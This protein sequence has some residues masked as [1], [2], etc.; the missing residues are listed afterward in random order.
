VP[1]LW[2][3]PRFGKRRASIQERREAIGG[4]VQQRLTVELGLSLARSAPASTNYSVDRIQ[5]LAAPGNA[6]SSGAVQQ[7]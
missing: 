7:P 3:K 4:A 1:P 5:L 6:A 2:H